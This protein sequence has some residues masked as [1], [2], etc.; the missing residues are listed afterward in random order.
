MKDLLKLEKL[1]TKKITICSGVFLF[2][3]N[4]H[5]KFID[6]CYNIAKIK[7]EPLII[8][9]NS[10]EYTK[11]KHNSYTP[12]MEF[13]IREAAVRDYLGSRTAEHQVLLLE[14]DNFF[15]THGSELNDFICTWIASA[16]YF[17]D[18]HKERHLSD[19]NIY[20]RST[21]DSSRAILLTKEK[22]CIN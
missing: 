4:G 5:K 6:Y 9:I 11:Q 7:K 14:E 15:K 21:D 13:H 1:D 16:E 12:E 19:V 10:T 18:Y 8:C 17:I 22:T 20:Y 2:F 3:H